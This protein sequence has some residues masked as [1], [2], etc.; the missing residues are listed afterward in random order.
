MDHP[1]SQFLL[2]ELK[3]AGVLST[4]VENLPCGMI[5]AS[6]DRKI[7]FCNRSAQAI[8]GYPADQILGRACASFVCNA[9]ECVSFESG[10]TIAGRPERLK[11]T[12][13]DGREITLTYQC[14]QIEP[15]PGRAYGLLVFLDVT[16]S[17]LDEDAVQMVNELLYEAAQ[18]MQSQ[19]NTDGLTGLLNHRA[20]Q[21]R[22]REE[23]SRMRRHRRPLSL[24]M[25]DVDHF[26]RC[27]DTYGHP[28]GDKVLRA[29]S[30]T[31]RKVCRQEDIVARY[32]GEEFTL[33]LP[34]TPIE[35]ARVMA[36]RLRL[37]VEDMTVSAESIS[38][39]V[40]ISCGVACVYPDETTEGLDRAAQQVID[41]ADKSLYLA[42][43][44]GRN[45][46]VVYGDGENG[47]Q[48]S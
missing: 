1:S 43:H 14:G 31:A 35:N 13:K 22:L 48:A 45:C 42:K 30:A 47:N 5:L 37:A 26:K 29:L 3:D 41:R 44:A 9:K 18:R 39:K 7:V 4:L 20:F 38:T 17:A 16:E 8:T 36:E 12:R 23:L 40:T 34:E 24:V 33:I 15:I 21:E 2:E 32:G 6:G 19:A 25:C 46:V 27:N 11:F 28:F 10:R